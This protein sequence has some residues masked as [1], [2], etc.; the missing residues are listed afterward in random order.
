MDRAEAKAQVRDRAPWRRDAWERS[1]LLVVLIGGC[2]VDRNRDG[3]R[4]HENR[5][6][7]GDPLRRASG[8]REHEDARRVAALV[9]SPGECSAEQ[10]VAAA[11]IGRAWGGER[12]WK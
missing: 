11:E 3:R 8:T 2:H 12:V 6:A 9:G 4:P 10:L 5:R 1:R 7:V